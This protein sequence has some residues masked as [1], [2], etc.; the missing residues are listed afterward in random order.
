METL[1]EELPLPKIRECIKT[2]LKVKGYTYKELANK[3][4]ITERS[5]TNYLSTTRMSPKTVKRIAEA[6]DYPYELLVQGEQYYS[7]DTNAQWQARFQQ[8]QDYCRGLEARIKRPEQ[9]AG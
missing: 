2:Y 8:L 6:I 7:P 5:M 9:R 1:P 3:L 4:D